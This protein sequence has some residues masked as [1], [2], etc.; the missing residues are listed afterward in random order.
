MKADEQVRQFCLNLP[1]V[2]EGIKWDH[3]LTFM[4]AG[5]MFAV[6]ALHP[7]AT[8]RLSLKC[9]PDRFGELLEIDGVV[10]APYLARYHWVALSHWNALPRNELEALLRQSYQLVRAKLPARVRKELEGLG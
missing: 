4:I 5:K 6:L 7:E 3:D 10:P 9:T 8:Q 2:E 1:H